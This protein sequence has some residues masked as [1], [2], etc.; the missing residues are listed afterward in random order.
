MP[1]L[2]LSPFLSYYGKTNRREG[3]G[4]GKITSPSRLGGLNV[5]H[6]LRI[7]LVMEMQ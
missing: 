1:G 2:Q 4:G 5:T 3:K 7:Y 6:I